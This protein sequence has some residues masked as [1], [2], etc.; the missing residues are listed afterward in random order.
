MA[1]PIVQADFGGFN[2][3]FPGVTVKVGSEAALRAFHEYVRAP[4]GQ[5]P[6]GD[7]LEA[8]A[9][10]S[11]LDH[12]VRH[13]HDALLS[14]YANTVFRLRLQSVV[15]GVQ[16]M[17]IA[18]EVEGELM[19]VP[20]AR[21][22]TT[23]ADARAACVEEWQALLA[24]RAS[25]V[26]LPP[27]TLEELLAEAEP[28]IVSFHDASALDGFQIAAE[29][30]VRAYLRIDQVTAGFL[31]EYVDDPPWPELQPFLVYEVL[32]LCVQLHAIWIGQGESQAVAFARHL[33][34]SP[35]PYAS[36]WRRVYAVAD[37]ASPA[38]ESH[39]SGILRV[40][41][42]TRQ[43]MAMAQWAV[44][45]FYQ[46]D[47]AAAC[48]AVRLMALVSHLLGHGDTRHDFAYEFK[49]T[50]DHWDARIGRITPWRDALLEMLAQADRAVQRYDGIR[51]QWRA[52][53]AM[54]AFVSDVL[55][56]QVAAQ[57]IVVAR[58]LEDP[59]SYV[60]PAAYVQLP[61]GT[62]PVPVVRLE[63]TGGYIPLSD[64]DGGAYVPSTTITSD[65]VEYANRWIIRAP[66][67]DFD[68]RRAA[69]ESFERVTQL[70][71]VRGR[72]FAVHGAAPGANSASNCRIT[73]S[74]SSG[75]V[76]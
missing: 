69:A 45:G 12:E 68:A 40:L 33:M 28:G 60:N 52:G 54:P 37:R 65:G 76:Q 22:M 50:W 4:A 41:L 1:E 16:A 57:K 24:T 6:A 62:L 59:E 9:L 35:L 74:M 8:I 5:V 13:Y 27:K 71:D 15:S 66:D 20:L 49:A 63:V 23:S 55:A 14:P 31:R 43:M 61:F 47:G 56:R 44:L 2:P 11:V 34:R 46:T 36:L 42:V 3:R 53:P 30:A 39:P 73:S 7:S 67:A 21:W 38:V 51:A 18:R 29:N 64:F 10:R 19:P 70:C 48:P 32:A 75:L 72:R 25:T 26:S 58:V 17:V